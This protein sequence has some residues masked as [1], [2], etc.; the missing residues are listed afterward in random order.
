MSRFGFWNCEVETKTGSNSSTLDRHFVHCS[1]N[2]FILVASPHEGLKIRH[3][4]ASGGNAM[5]RP[6]FISRRLPIESPQPISPLLDTYVTRHVNIKNK[7]DFD[8]PRR[9]C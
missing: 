3:R 2:M 8:V 9:V 1:G 6:A 7:E 4:F 5:K